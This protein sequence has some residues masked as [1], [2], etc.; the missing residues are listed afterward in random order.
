MIGLVASLL[1][2][3]TNREASDNYLVSLSEPLYY[4]P[5]YLF[6]STDGFLF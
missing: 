4:V 5:W 1:Q 2:Y 6:E 3:L